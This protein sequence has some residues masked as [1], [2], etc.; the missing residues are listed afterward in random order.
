[1]ITND[2]IPDFGPLAD[3][4]VKAAVDRINITVGRSFGLRNHEGTFRVSERASYVSRGVVVLYTQ[5][6]RPQF[7]EA[8]HMH[9]GS[10]TCPC[11]AMKNEPVW[12]DFAKGTEEELLAQIVRR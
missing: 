3:A 9:F 5:R 1:M 10:F 8:C 12:D 6:L 4:A 2:T 11:V 7:N